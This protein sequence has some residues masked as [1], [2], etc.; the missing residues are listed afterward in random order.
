MRDGTSLGGA[1]LLEMSRAELDEL[2]RSRPAGSLPTG[3]GQGTAIVLPGTPLAK[4]VAPIVRLL[5]WQGKVFRSDGKLLKNVV[6]PFGVRAIMAEVY[7]A[8][9]W[10]DGRECIVLDYSRRSLVARKI[11]DEIREISPGVYLGVVYLGRKKTI[12]FALAF[13]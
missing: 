3:R 10:L 1:Q 4:I 9:S 12:N 6:T 8:P 2:F 7:K 11:R 5:A 13:S